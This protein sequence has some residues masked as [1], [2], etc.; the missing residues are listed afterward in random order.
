MSWPR[1]RLVVSACF[2]GAFRYDGGR[3]REPVLEALRPHV[4]LIPVCPEVGVGL[5]VPRPTVRLVRRGEGV[6]LVQPETGEDLTGKMEA[7]SERFLEALPEVDGFL[8]K[9]RSPSC[10]L[11]DAKVYA[12]PTGGGTVARGP[13]LFARKVLE[14][15]PF[16]PVE[17]EGRLRDPAI[18]A[19][20]LTRLF[21]LARLRETA[22][23]G[24]LMA[25]HARYKLLLLAYDPQAA[26]DLG[27]LL[28]RSA[29][30]L[31]AKRAYREGF[32]RATAK[33][34]RPG[35]M[36]D[37][38]LHA[39]GH[40]DGLSR[41]EKAYFLERLR[42]FRE[43]RLSLEALLTL[44]RAWALRFRAP[45]LEAQALLEPFP[46]ALKGVA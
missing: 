40:L 6:A 15:F 1:P 13:G 36:A 17:E 25:F 7:F 30:F 31:E 44:L 27:R 18:L 29:S 28:A 11:K 32:L 23:L 2:L 20:F 39:F 16:F 33:L 34:P 9:N 42:D 3:V 46:P 8:L 19:S 24:E 38:L 22:S 45:Y 4:D 5:G 37:A 14:A 12:H 21:A 26:R 35:R 41:E 10:A 43:G